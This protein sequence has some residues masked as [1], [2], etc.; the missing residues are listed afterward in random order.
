MWVYAPDRHIRRRGPIGAQILHSAAY[1]RIKLKLR[2]ETDENP[3]MNNSVAN[4]LVDLGTKDVPALPQVPLG[5]CGCGAS[6]VYTCGAYRLCEEC[7]WSLAE[8]GGA[9]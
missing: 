7:S 3:F 2:A 1:I 6:A 9:P 5:L 4:S 8:Q